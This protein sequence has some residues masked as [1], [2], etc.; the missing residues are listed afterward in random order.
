MSYSSDTV[1]LSDVLNKETEGTNNS[2]CCP[3]PSQ[4]VNGTEEKGQ[5]SVCVAQ[6]DLAL[7]CFHPAWHYVL[8][9]FLLIDWHMMCLLCASDAL[10]ESR[11]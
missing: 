2:P 9:L 10:S 3:A 6:E 5:I 8:Y 4:T 11:V 1:A 7:A